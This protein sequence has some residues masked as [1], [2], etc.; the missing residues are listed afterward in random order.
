M[1]DFLKKLEKNSY[2]IDKFLERNL[3]TGDILNKRLIES[4]K[5]S[6]ISGGKKIRAFL[7]METGKLLAKIYNKTYRKKN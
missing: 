7:V 6:A 5:Y 2:D 1:D 3:P 4:I